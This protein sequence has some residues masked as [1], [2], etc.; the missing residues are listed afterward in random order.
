MADLLPLID[1]AEGA[2]MEAEA[3]AYRR[4]LLAALE[5]SITLTPVMRVQDGT[6]HS[7][8]PFAP[9]V[10][11]PAEDASWEWRRPFAVG[12]SS[13]WDLVQS[14]GPTI[15]PAGV[16]APNDRRVQG[17]L[18]VLEDRMDQVWTKSHAPWIAFFKSIDAK[19][20]DEWYYFGGVGHQA[21]FE[22]RTSIYLETDDISSF[23]RGLFVGYAAEVVPGKRYTFMEGSPHCAAP[24]KIF[25][26]AA[27]VVHLR[28]MLI[29]EDG[30]ALWLARGIP[31][32]WL[33]QGK[34]ISVKNAPTHFGALAYEIVSDVDHGKI[35]AVVVMPSRTPPKS[36]LLRFRHPKEL[37]MKGVTINGKEWKD[38][39]TV[40]EVVKLHDLKDNVS[41]EIRY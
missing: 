21:G 12:L 33:E 26:E 8:I 25:E 38:F 27:F 5:R 24:N 20:G 14:A 16:L 28:S 37:P 22:R 1:P 41:V 4:D 3:E 19:T 39:D 15:S 10:R 34:R 9:Y 18:D 31:R 17:W 11:G 30:P 6:Y 7:C 32:G 23:L 40:K 35:G 36:V 2:K 29:M 13:Y